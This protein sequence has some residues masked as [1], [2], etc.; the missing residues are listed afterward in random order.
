MKK[1]VKTVKSK[2]GVVARKTR[3]ASTGKAVKTVKT[4]KT[5][6]TVKAGPAEKVLRKAAEKIRRKETKSPTRKG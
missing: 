2:T 6:K 1:A 5:A 3:L 4:L